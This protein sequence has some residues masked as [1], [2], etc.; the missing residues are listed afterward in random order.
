MKPFMKLLASLLALGV[1]SVGLAAQSTSASLNDGAI[2]A[3]ATQKLAAKQ[4]FRNLRATAEDGIATLTGTVELYQQKL[5][6]AKAVRKLPN[7][8]GVRNLIAVEGKNVPDA[9]LTAQLDRKIFYDRIGYDN[10]F[11]YVAASVKDGVAVLNGETRTEFDRNSALSLVDNTPGVKDVVDN[12]QVSPVSNFDDS[13]RISASRAIYRDPILG[14][15]GSD[16]AMPIRIVVAN[17]HLTLYGTVESKMDKEIAG[18]R[19]NQIPGVFSVQNDLEIAG[20]S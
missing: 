10:L 16:P 19:A 11:N 17:G 4:E 13:I 15:Y 5:D 14:R 3:R 12:I 8:Q 1:L 18:I 7:V 6:A 9:D 20:H 2:Q